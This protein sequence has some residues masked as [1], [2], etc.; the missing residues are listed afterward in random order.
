MFDVDAET[1]L[2]PIVK[3]I[4]SVV[5]EVIDASEVDNPVLQ[6]MNYFL[7]TATFAAHQEVT[8]IEDKVDELI[9]KVDKVDWELFEQTF[10]N[11][12]SRKTGNLVFRFSQ[13]YFDTVKELFKT[14]REATTQQGKKTAYTTALNFVKENSIILDVRKLF[15]DENLWGVRFSQAEINSHIDDLKANLGEIGYERYYKRAKEKVERYKDAVESQR[16]VYSQAH[17]ANIAIVDELMSLWEANNSPAKAA[18]MMESAYEIEKIGDSYVTPTNK[19][20]ERVPL[21]YKD[22]K[23]TGFYDS[24]FEKIEANENLRNLYDYILETLNEMKNY[25]PQEE[26]SWMQVNSLPTIYKT[27]M[28]EYSKD[29]LHKGLAPIRDALKESVR[30][31]DV[32]STDKR[33]RN[34]L[35]SETDKQIQTDMIVDYSA[36]IREL[37]KLKIEEYNLSNDIPATASMIKEFKKDAADEV[38]K[39][40][41]F[42]LGKVTKA[43]SLMALSYKHKSAVQDVMEAADNMIK[44]QV[45]QQE[46]AARKDLRDVDGNPIALKGLKN[47]RKMVNT[48]MDV[49]Y[50]YQMDKPFG[51]TKKKIYTDRENAMKERYEAVIEKAKAKLDAGEINQEE[52]DR[53]I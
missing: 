52:Y 35:T 10:S 33:I 20:V 51:Q 40:K 23:A 3:D 16:E 28:E 43:F 34:P 24:K 27:V 41:S 6:A 5:S 31:S 26:I 4:S 29:G 39:L 9:N 25:L 14:A 42:D 22:G 48:L 18:E 11:S 8:V 21:R 1:I 49:Y 15:P 37:V 45:E 7:K 17:G 2:N 36:K 46:T 44:R 38:S 47:T 19:Y 12:D 13:E 53:S 30:T 50:G 32:P